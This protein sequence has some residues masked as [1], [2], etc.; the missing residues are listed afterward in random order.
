M[1]SRE[2]SAKGGLGRIGRGPC[3]ILPAQVCAGRG[4]MGFPGEPGKPSRLDSG[5]PPASGL[6][7]CKR[8]GSRWV[9]K[10]TLQLV[11]S[12]CPL[13]PAPTRLEGAALRTVGE[14]LARCKKDGGSETPA[15]ARS[16][17]GAQH[18]PRRQ[19]DLSFCLSQPMGLALG[20]GDGVKAVLPATPFGLG[21]FS[22]RYTRIATFLVDT[23]FCPLTAVYSPH[24]II[25][26]CRRGH[27]RREP[28]SSGCLDGG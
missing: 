7:C 26:Q 21:L 25:P 4:A 19:T 16:S 27:P 18:R 11:G 22:Y 15:G 12:L 14:E 3:M 20:P 8:H 23:C 2:A 28:W 24:P 6:G 1:R 13:P 9:L 5:F 10:P 17:M